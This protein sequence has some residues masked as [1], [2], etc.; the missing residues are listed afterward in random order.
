MSKGRVMSI[1]E[2]F[3]P[4]YTIKREDWALMRKSI[5]GATAIEAEGTAYLPVPPAIQVQ[6]GST[7]S[8]TEAYSFYK[9][10]AEYFE[11]TQ[12]THS[13]IIGMISS[14]DPVIE[15]PKSMEY[16]HESATVDGKNLMELWRDINN[17]VFTTGRIGLLPE[18]DEA[19]EVNGEDVFL[20]Q[21]IAESLMDWSVDKQS[22]AIESNFVKLVEW[23]KE[24]DMETFGA[25]SKRR[26]RILT[27][28][29]TEEGG[30]KFLT[31]FVSPYFEKDENPELTQVSFEEIQPEYRGK[32]IEFMPFT[33]INA[34]DLEY[35]VGRIPLGQVARADLSIYQ[36]MAT[37]NRAIYLMCD[38]TYFQI[39]VDEVELNDNTLT[40]GG[41]IWY[42]ANKDAKMGVIDISGEGIPLQKQAIDDR[43]NRALMFAGRLVDDNKGGI[44]SGEALRLRTSSQNVTV[45]SVVENLARGLEKALKNIAVIRGDN[46]EEVK[47][48][49]NLDFMRPE[50]TAQEVLQF[51][52]AKNQGA[53][54][55]LESLH[56]MFKQRGLDLDDFEV[57]KETIEQEGP[58]DI[59]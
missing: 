54:I 52:Q 4:Q 33:P 42:S 45:S 25:T 15:L 10:F 53:P 19:P 32:K 35:N 20:C 37:Y 49:A 41:S 5:E 8:N 7:A 55:N 3:N 12:L 6:N 59:I 50:I 24:V 36:K 51:Q 21:Y 38:P 56:R 11:I 57:I 22:S 29:G 18:I 44:E 43:F 26:L 47:V 13:G 40:G 1:F 9:G 30:E 31:L 58:T 16:L 34:A 48:T 2:N 27:F 39:G 17:E 14:V 23:K 46:V 28:R